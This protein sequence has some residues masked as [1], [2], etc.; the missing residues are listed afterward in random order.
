MSED[1]IDMYLLF[2]F[3]LRET[4]KIKHSD[5]PSPF[6]HPSSM[7]EIVLNIKRRDSNINV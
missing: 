6:F 5:W 7:V 3:G 1:F 4:V 2:I